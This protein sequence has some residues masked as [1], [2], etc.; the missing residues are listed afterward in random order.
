MADGN[1]QTSN[2]RK[3]KDSLDDEL[4]SI[5][6]W[7]RDMK[8]PD[9]GFQVPEGYFDALE[10]RVMARIEAEGL[11]QMP[12][13][14]V[15][16][17]GRWWQQPRVLMAAAAVLC[18]VLAAV[19][20]LRPRPQANVVAVEFS[21]EE[22]ADYV[23]EN[24]HEF[25]LEQLASIPKETWSEADETPAAPSDIQGKKP[26]AGDEFAPEDVDKLLDDMS[27]EELESIF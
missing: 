27:D 14:Q 20:L 19:W 18:G 4:K 10:D 16:R 5:S 22:A 11:R 26:A 6:P 12:A 24:V 13:M 25:D 7:L 8:R 23:F 17:G 9:D 1:S 3:M 21:A 15:R 2:S